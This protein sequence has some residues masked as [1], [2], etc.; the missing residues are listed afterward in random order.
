MESSFV[1][2]KDKSKNFNYALFGNP[3]NHSKSPQIH[4]LFSKQT[5]IFHVYKAIKIPINQF[6][7][8]VS[9][10]FKYNIQGANVTAPFK[11]EAYFFSNKL[12]KRAQI[13][14]SVNTLKKVNNTCILGD[15]TDGIGLLSDLNRLKFI[16]KNFSILILG[17]GG[18]IQGILLSILSLGCSVY[19]LNRTDSNASNLV[20]QFR[21][22]G[23]IKIFKKNDLKIKYF[24]LVIN[25]L[26]R[27]IQYDSSI[28]PLHLFTNKTFFYDMNYGLKNISFLNLCFKIDSNHIADGIGML[29][30][31]AAYSFL[32]WHGIFPQIDYIIDLLNK[33]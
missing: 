20:N 33:S 17:A 23:K 28:I 26:S 19:I 4:N 3:I 13:A 11:K 16:Q 9:D 8:L 10:F 22:Y 5:G 29:V 7:L 31:Q 32:E 18:A 14:Q 12:T 21:Q 15:N 6:S 24:D 1:M 2:G 27:N 25:G 30:F